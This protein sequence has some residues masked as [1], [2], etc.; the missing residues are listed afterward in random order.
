[1]QK[2][3]KVNPTPSVLQFAVNPRAQAFYLRFWFIADLLMAIAVVTFWVT[4]LVWVGRFFGVL[5]PLEPNLIRTCL[6]VGGVLL[7]GIAA[8]VLRLWLRRAYGI[9]EVIF[10]LV[11]AWGIMSGNNQ[12]SRFDILIGFATT[13]YLIVRGLDNW[14][15]GVE[16]RA[17]KN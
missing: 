3:L 7:A 14:Y 12:F 15:Q 8:Y 13:V 5:R 16:D 6:G 4:I 2:D 11:V 9:A 10:A 17:S 1:M